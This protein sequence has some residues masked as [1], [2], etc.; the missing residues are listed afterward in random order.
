MMKLKSFR[1]TNFR[2]IEDSGWIDTDDVSTLIGTNESGKTNLLLPLWKLNPAKEG[3]IQAIADY[4]RSRYTEIRGMDE[5]PIFIRAR[6][7]VGDVLI[8]EIAEITNS[9]GEQLQILEVA[10]RF[11][12]D[13]LVTFPHADKERT[14]SSERVLQVLE[15]GL[16]DINELPARDTQEDLRE[17]MMA[18]LQNALEEAPEDRESISGNDLSTILDGL[19]S[20]K[21]GN[22][23]KKSE[24]A[25]RYRSIRSSLEEL[26]TQTQSPHPDDVD[27]AQ[28]WAL[29]NIPSFVYY[30]NYGN[31]DS[32]IYLPHVIDDMK[33]SGL[34]DKKAAKTRTLKVLFDFVGLEPE[35]ILEL[36]RDFQDLRN[37]NREPTDEEISEIRE[38]K[39]EREV[40]L[41]SASNKLTREFRDW[42]KQGDYIFR[43]QADGDHFRIWVSDDRRPE[44]IELE[45][46]SAGLQ[47]FLSFFL[48][49]LVESED[50]HEDAI[51]LLDEPGLSLHPIAQE[52]LS[53]FFESLSQT[54]QLI[55]TTHSPFMVDS[56]RL[57]RV[58]AV[59]VGDQGRTQ[60]S[61]DLRS[62]EK[63]EGRKQS[64]YPVN[65]ALGLS[66]SDA[67]LLGCQSIIVEGASDQMY[68]SAMKSYLVSSGK[69]KPSREIIFIPSSGVRGVKAIAR[70][71]TG[72]NERPPHVLLDADS[73]GEGMTNSLKN[74]DLY[75]DEIARVLSVKDFTGMDETET[76]DLWPSDFL[77]D[78]ASRYVLR[79]PLPDFTDVFS[80]DKPIV[81]Q[82]ESYADEHDIDLSP[83]WKVE[84][85]KH[86]KRTLLHNPKKIDPDSTK[87]GKWVSL[88]ETISTEN[89]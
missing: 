56:D 35:E 26:V 44:E 52:D 58:K 37:P 57:D 7:N 64:I 46:R 43:F 80:D 11:D 25:R 21:L 49:F 82:M 63:E 42:W 53:R 9:P 34:G 77:A 8:D 23:P 55:Y 71:L 60:V 32:E 88:F 65:A 36:G 68:L 67:L 17:R 66:V 45:G 4:P 51:L 13:Y 3:E 75:Q 22:A 31:L 20:V 78:I 30:S 16:D 50:S 24:I 15:E 33:R 5:K 84:L 41:Q 85:A 10:R 28:K 81:P 6:F 19:E 89:G 87:V 79:G 27:E 14:A 73:A 62:P 2:S 83:G 86:T 40:L 72:R 61:P 54:N 74:S 76:E 18:A 38:N 59:Y 12:G 29:E 70:I 1:V 69:M 39:R 48:V 47:W